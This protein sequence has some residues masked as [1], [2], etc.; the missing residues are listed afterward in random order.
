MHGKRVPESL[1]S[2]KQQRNVPMPQTEHL[3]NEGD[4]LR[5]LPIA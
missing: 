4:R 5:A 2:A 3:C 1:Q